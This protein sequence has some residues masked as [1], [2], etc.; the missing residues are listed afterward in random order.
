MRVRA[1]QR[2]AAFRGWRFSADERAFCRHVWTSRRLLILDGFLTPRGASA[3]RLFDTPA[4]SRTSLRRR[5]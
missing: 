1:F 4:G 5:R 2:L 3:C